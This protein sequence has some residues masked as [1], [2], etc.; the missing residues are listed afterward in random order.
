MSLKLDHRDTESTANVLTS[1]F[2]LPIRSD[3]IVWDNTLREGEQPPGVVFTPDEKLEI[4]R[5]MD[6]IGITHATIGFPAVSL[7]EKKAVIRIVKAGLKMKLSVMARLV[8]TD[9]DTAIDCGADFVGVFLPGSEV[10][11]R[12]KLKISEAEGLKKVE[13]VIRRA[14]DQKIRCYFAIEDCS[15]MPLDRIVRMFKVA[16]DAGAEYLM[17]ADTVGVLTPFSTF[18]VVK[19]LKSMLTKP[20]ILHFHDDLGLA[21]ANSLAGLQAG[22]KVVQATVNGAGER[23]GNTCFEELAVVLKVKYGVDLGFQLHKL[24]DLCQLVH[25]ASGTTPS[26]HKSV[27]GKWCF[28][29]ESGIHVAGV[30]ANQE[31]YQPF[32]PKL[33]GRSHEIIFG[34]HSGLQSVRHLA[35]VHGLNPS[36]DTL[37]KVLDQI[38][39]EAEKKQTLLSDTQILEW[40]RSH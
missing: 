8:P 12:D 20:L 6:A 23:S 11:L 37:K 30:L 33:I 1:S 36:D 3:I 34:K 21:L 4:A 2:D 18:Q 29:H 32:P 27:T 15:R 39:A 26:A 40:I 10:H 25:K 24:N 28:S 13:E 31:A 7:D 9:V 22:A 38:K 17:I 16:S 35:T 14:T 5:A 19:A